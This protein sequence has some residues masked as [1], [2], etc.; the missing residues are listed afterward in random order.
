MSE[1]LFCRERG[2]KLPAA[3]AV[4]AAEGGPG[5]ARSVVFGFDGSAPEQETLQ[6]YIYII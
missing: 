6:S 5:T 4:M 2:G 3:T 1:G